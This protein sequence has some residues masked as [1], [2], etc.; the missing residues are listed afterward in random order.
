LLKLTRIVA[1][2]A[3]LSFLT[4]VGKHHPPEFHEGYD[5]RARQMN[6]HMTKMATQSSTSI[7]VSIEVTSR[8]HFN[9]LRSSTT[10]D[11]PTRSGSIAQN[12]IL[13]W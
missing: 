11:A 8:H 9:I 1:L 4:Y 10:T 2:G 12:W 13:A 3:F 6:R 7:M 5:D